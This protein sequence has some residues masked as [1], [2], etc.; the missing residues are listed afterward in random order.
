MSNHWASG[1]PGSVISDR[2]GISPVLTGYSRPM[3]V[4]AVL[5]DFDGVIGDNEAAM[6][7]AYAKLQAHYLGVLPDVEV[8]LN[9]AHTPRKFLKEHISQIKKDE[10][11]EN[12][13]SIYLSTPIFPMEGAQ[14]VMNYYDQ[15]QTPWAVVSNNMNTINRWFELGF[16]HAY[17]NTPVYANAGK[18]GHDAYV[19][20]MQTIGVKP[21]KDVI[22]VDDGWKGLV[23]AARLGLTPVY[24]GERANI[25]IPQAQQAM[26]QEGIVDTNI[27]HVKDNAEL[28]NLVHQGIQ[29]TAPMPH[30]ERG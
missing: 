17:P 5:S 26:Q 28:L 16:N 18:P 10:L 11:F 23:A 9:Y 20:A 25:V 15:S 21:G 13:R 1:Q 4:K 24:M 14:D 2:H 6:R 30:F 22:M 3:K 8:A 29:Q 7:K 19:R 27:L 12:G